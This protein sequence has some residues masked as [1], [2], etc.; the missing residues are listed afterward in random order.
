MKEILKNQFLASLVT[1]NQCIQNCP[2]AEWNQPH[3]DSPFSQA[4][5]H[6]LYYTDLYL[7][8]DA[9]EFKSQL[10]HENNKNLF[11]DYDPGAEKPDRFYTKKDI[12]LYFKFCL[13]KADEYYNKIDN[14]LEKSGHKNMTHLELSIY[15]TRHVQHH[16]AQLGLRIQQITKQELQWIS[17]GYD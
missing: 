7:S 11:A 12:L 1:F 13:D 17:S 5:F 2:D 8:R 14:W 10:F 3:N 9:H 6:T 16:A 4:L 15:N